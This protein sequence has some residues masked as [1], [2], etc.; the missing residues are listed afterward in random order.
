MR[1]CSLP[2]TLFPFFF[3][4]RTTTMAFAGW[5]VRQLQVL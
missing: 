1:L 3:L 2:L 4:A 5:T